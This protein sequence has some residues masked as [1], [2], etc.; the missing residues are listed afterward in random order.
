MASPFQ[1]QSLRRKLIYI[2][3]ILVLFGVTTFGVR[4]LEFTGPAPSWTV[5]GRAN[6]LGLRQQSQGD[7]ELT[8]SAIRLLLTGSRGF[9]VC[10][11]WVS[12]QDKQMRHEWNELEMIVRSLT[13]LQPHFITPWLFQ[14]WNLSYNVSVESDLIRDKYFYITRGIEL[15]AEGE[16]QNRNHPDLRFTMGFYNQHKIGLADENNTFRC[17]YQ[18]SSMDPQERDPNWLRPPE[19]GARPVVVP[20]RFEQFCRQHPMLVRRLRE[21]L[22]LQ[23]PDD[24]V[25]FLKDNWDIPS[26]YVLTRAAQDGGQR[27]A[28]PPKPEL[29]QFPILPPH[30]DSEWPERNNQDRLEDEDSNYTVARAWY[31]YSLKPMPP[32]DPIPRF[33]TVNPDPTKYR[34]PRYIAQHIFRGYPA[35][36]QT[37]VAERYAQEGWFDREG[38]LI[39]GWFKDDRFSDGREARV[40][41]SA[42]WAREAWDRAFR[43]WQ[44]HGILNG[45]YKTREELQNLEDQ[46]D[47]YRKAYEILPQM[48]GPEPTGSRA[49]PEIV[50]GYRAHDQIYWY[51]RNRHMTN[52]PHFYFKTQVELREE[53]VQA[54]KG[55]FE[56]E[57]LR[58]AGVQEKALEAYAKAL[59]LWKTVLLDHPDFAEDSTIQEDS[60]ETQYKY[61]ELAQE[62]RG[63]RVKPLAVVQDHLGQAALRPPGAPQWLPPVQLARGVPVGF[64]GPLEGLDR[65]GYPLLRP[66]ARQRV[67][68]RLGIVDPEPQAQAPPEMPPGMK[69]K[70]MIESTIPK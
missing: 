54:R 17:L 23:T 26:R 24:V 69:G 47:A 11:L 14:S 25:D 55:F 35:R 33:L 7:V 61:L 49:T 60:Y 39:R 4:G 8:G 2:G 40:G 56:A 10:A 65:R 12:A 62:V 34:M 70:R 67:R 19:A 57:Q 3:L 38:W 16:R 27:L 43:M 50:A 64:V 6:A 68:Q 46:A 29:E 53:T 44:Q 5:T 37:Y 22:R 31:A 13:K 42:P 48:A 58:R 45:L 32:P 21:V 30:F 9:A 36:A 52:F 63:R 41:D 20:E 28:S 18:L 1:Q 51:E 66:D 59:A 15:L